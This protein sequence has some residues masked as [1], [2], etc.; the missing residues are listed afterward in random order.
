ITYDGKEYD[1]NFITYGMIQDGGTMK[2][3]M[4]DK[5]DTTRGTS[6]E[7]APYSFS[8]EPIVKEL[9]SE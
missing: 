7:A 9:L 4:T 2:F 1:R 5:P 8:D 3:F 6:E